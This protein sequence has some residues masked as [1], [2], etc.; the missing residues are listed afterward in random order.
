MEVAYLYTKV[1]S[2]FGKQV[3]FE[4]FITQLFPQSTFLEQQ[5]TTVNYAIPKA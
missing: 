1:R 2:D 5:G 3:R 4:D